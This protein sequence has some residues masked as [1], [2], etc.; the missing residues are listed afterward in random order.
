MLYVGI[1]VA[2]NK[3]DLAV[4][5]ENGNIF[6]QNFRFENSYLG[7]QELQNHLSCLSEP[8]NGEIRIALEDTGHYAYNLVK[9]LR[10]L[11]YPVFTYNALLIREFVKSQ[12]LRKTKTDVKDA[13]MIARKLY[14]DTNSERFEVD[15]NTQELKELT[16]YQ[17]RLIQARSKNKSLYVRLLDIM[18]PEFAKIVG[19]VHNNYVYE[20]L[21][22]YPTPQ[23]IKHAH[24]DSLLKIKRLT[25]VKAGQIQEAA[26][27][28][29]GNPSPALQIE[30]IQL[31]ST[32]RHYDQQIDELQ[33][34]INELL[35]RIDSPILSITGIGN[36]LGAI[37]LAEIKN[38]D[39]FSSPAQLQAFAGL[40]PSIYQSG[41]MDNSGRMVKRG[42]HYLRYALIQ[43][44][45]MAT[46]YSPHFKAYL[47]LK[48][49]QGKHYFV[50]LSHVAKKLIRV[51]YY[52]LK[53]NQKFDETRLR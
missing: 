48:I 34:Q 16:R 44:A 53:T 13:L 18:F 51:I 2:K 28:T 4:I 9:F 30:L 22:S 7:F 43:A 24:F 52:L 33:A 49:S 45:R 42:S 36:R 14:G 19:N 10:K 40:E 6:S 31:I 29:I 21:T 37:I 47:K 39:N 17:N 38:I 27:L 25:A 8:F 46:V 50:A 23:K 26:H 11:S 41:Q 15:E 20:L 3:H 1:D 5:D 12:S 35:I 32:I